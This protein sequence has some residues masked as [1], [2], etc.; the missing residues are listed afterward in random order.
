M[1]RSLDIPKRQKG[2]TYRYVASTTQGKTVKGTIKA[3]GELAAER[4]LVG[5][6]LNPIELGVAP[7]MFSLEEAFPTFFKVKL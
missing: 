4:L 7:S 5:Q 2:V 6:G 1:A 3:T